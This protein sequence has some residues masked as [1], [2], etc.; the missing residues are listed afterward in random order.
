MISE[1]LYGLLLYLYPKKFRAAY[2]QQMRLTF[3]DACRA[4]YRRNGAGGL[5]ALWLPTLL[6]LFKSALEERARQGEIMMSKARLIALAGPLNV[7]VGAVALV[8]SLSSLISMTWTESS[9]NFWYFFSFF[10]FFLG[11]IPMLL[12]LIGTRLR[13]HQA[14]GIPGKLG[15]LLSVVG[16]GGM[17]VVA[18]AGLLVKQGSWI[19]YLAAA[20]LLSL[21]I[22]YVLFG[23]DALRY[24]LLP[25]WNWLPLL[26]G[27][28]I[29]Y[30]FL[31]A[32]FGVPSDYQLQLT[33]SVLHSVLMGVCWVL[34]GIAM[35][36][37]RRG[38]QSAA[39]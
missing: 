13:F 33:I 18:L 38:S 1:R 31:T 12:A 15:L 9:D 6:D 8:A 26:A 37:Q 20:C 30:W 39:I 7:L 27:S 36:D 3:H 5:L 2:G 10:I 24:R 23:I 19:S 16:C 35:M 14:A 29:V 25:R 21:M 34:L 22:G 11:F 32:L 28:T 17:I 4:A